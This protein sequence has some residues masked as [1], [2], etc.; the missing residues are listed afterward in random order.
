VTRPHAGIRSLPD[1]E[2]F[3]PLRA[4]VFGPDRRQPPGPPRRSRLM[5]YVMPALFLVIAGLGVANSAYLRDSRDM[6]LLLAGF[7]SAATV[8]P[9]VLAAVGRPLIAWRFAYP[10]L[11]VG[12]AYARPSEPWSPIQ[13][14]SYATI[15][16]LLAFR[17][18]PGVAPWAAALT[19][20][21][22]Y[23]LG[24]PAAAT[25]SL[26]LLLA[27]GLAGDAWARRRASSEQLAQ[28]ERLTERE[29]ER[30]SALEE[31]AR[32]AREMHDVVAHHMSMIAVQAET[33]PYRVTGLPEPALTEFRQMA[34]AA[35]SAMTDM[36]RL[37]GV[38]RS[39]TEETPTAPQPGLADVSTLVEIASRAGVTVTFPQE[40]ALPARVNEATGLTAYRIV[41]EALANAARHAP[42]GPVRVSVRGHPDLLLVEVW[43]GPGGAALPARIGDTAGGGHG[44]VGM[45]ER[46]AALGGTLEAEAQHDGG[47]LVSARLPLRD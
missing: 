38:L 20:V 47:F 27:I 44:L 41:Q 26:I 46:A 25:G 18:A 36:R 3:G 24:E 23:T 34:E 40:E 1:M 32:I 11:V 7:L 17:S 22:A 9:V 31:R 39:E 29:R 6:P 19:V 8:A 43:N 10:M 5:S 4:L 16:T 28:Q 12:T 2:I 14:L 21:P 13:L 15:F 37:L 30:R 45:R 33:A 35:R 42:G